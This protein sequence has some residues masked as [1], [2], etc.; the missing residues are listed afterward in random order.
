MYDIYYLHIYYT[1]ITYKLYYRTI[2]GI[3]ENNN[4]KK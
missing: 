3:V 1:N 2:L 4:K